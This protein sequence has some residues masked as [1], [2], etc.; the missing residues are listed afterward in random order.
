MY[1]IVIFADICSLIKNQ[2]HAISKNSFEKD[3]PYIICSFW[4]CD[5]F[6]LAK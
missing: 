1:Y 3:D 5:Y 2:S 4:N 6:I